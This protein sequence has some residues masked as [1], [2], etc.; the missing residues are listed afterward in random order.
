MATQATVAGSGYKLME[1]NWENIQRKVR[2]AETQRPLTAARTRHGG[3]VL[4]LCLYCTGAG[5]QTFTGWVNSHLKKNGR[6]VKDLERDLG[7]GAALRCPLC[8]GALMRDG[9]RFE[10]RQDWP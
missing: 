5:A 6:T 9:G 10:R 2:A 4:S 1:K 8:S 3:M 7:D